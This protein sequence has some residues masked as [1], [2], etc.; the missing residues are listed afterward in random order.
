MKNNSQNVFVCFQTVEN[1]L[2]S[3]ETSN[4]GES[5]KLCPNQLNSWCNRDRILQRSNILAQIASRSM[6][7]TILFYCLIH[8]AHHAAGYVAKLAPD[9]LIFIALCRERPGEAEF[10]LRFLRCP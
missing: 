9:E 6:K 2:L 3:G 5:L 8:I 1:T 4:L 7:Y 10:E